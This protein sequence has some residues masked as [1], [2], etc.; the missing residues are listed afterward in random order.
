MLPTTVTMSEPVVASH[1][2]SSPP[3]PLARPP[4]LVVEDDGSPPIPRRPPMI[5]VDSRAVRRDFVSAKTTY[6]L[7]S[8]RSASKRNRHLEVYD[9]A[10]YARV[11]SLYPALTP[12]AAHGSEHAVVRVSVYDR[13]VLAA[14]ACL[15]RVRRC[16]SEGK[17]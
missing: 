4:A 17:Q 1:D 6:P 12:P 8:T 11:R 10:A 5:S 15:R 2:V 16:K 7:L 14:E 13:C 3:S 9:A